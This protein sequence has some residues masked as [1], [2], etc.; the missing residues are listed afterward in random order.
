MPRAAGHVRVHVDHVGPVA[1][2]R[3]AARRRSR[4]TSPTGRLSPVSADSATSSVAASSRR[5]SAGTMSP[6]SIATTSPGTSCSAGNSTS[7]A[8]AA[9]P[10]L[11]EHH[12]LE[13]RDR[14]RRLALLVQA[15]DRVEE[16]SAGGRR[17]R[18]RTRAA[19]R[20]CRCRRRAGRPASRRWYCRTNACQRGSGFASA[21][22][23]GPYC[24]PSARSTSARR[25]ALRRVD[26]ELRGRLG[27]VEGVPRLDWSAGRLSRWTWYVSFDGG[28]GWRSG[29]SAERVEDDRE[30]SRRR[31]SRRTSPA[32]C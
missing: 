28:R 8:V 15:E 6:A 14:L 31:P 4:P 30:R 25:E 21:N 9:N 26:A 20:C 5:P 3:V 2:R 17:C 19:A 18:C 11:D 13:R 29:S 24:S 27:G 1:E 12:L 10:R 16:R 22:L 23:F 7:C 32:R